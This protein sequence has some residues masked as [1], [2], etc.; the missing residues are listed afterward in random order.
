[1]AKS[2]TKR[3]LVGFRDV[4][5]NAHAFDDLTNQIRNKSKQFK[6]R[7]L[8]PNTWNKKGVK[9]MKFDAV[10]GNPPYQDSEKVNN[11]QGAI[12]HY[13]YDI[14]SELS[15][16]YSLI[17]PARFLFNTGFTP[18][19]WN[20]KMLNDEH[21]NIV[22]Y[23]EDATDIFPRT[24][25]KGGIIISYHDMKQNFGAIKKFVPDK[26]LKNIMNHFSCDNESNLPSIMYGGRSDLKFNN[27]FIK[28][29]P[30]SIQDRI[31]VIKLKHP[32][33]N[34]LSPNEEFELKSSTFEV[35]PYAFSETNIEDADTYKILGLI[36]GK[37]VYR[38]IPRKYMVA[39]YPERNNINAYKVFVPESNGSGTFG[40]I[41]STPVV[42]EPYESCT[43][44]F[45]SIGN[46]ET[47]IE[48]ENT[49]KYIKTKLCR[50][51]LGIMKKTQ[52]NSAPNWAYIPIQD[53]TNNSDIDWSKNIS[54]ID[55]QLYSK[56][57]LSE[58][59]ITYIESTIR[60]ME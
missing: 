22:R 12:Y 53:F 55:K 28:D 43:P 47:K 50:A 37:R 34:S 49:L 6:E 45:I 29:Y 57:D 9:E 48:A 56:Y 44:T 41:L 10:V 5:I 19:E 7:I 15:D 23:E 35:L 51:L 11:R 21:F 59:E 33:V 40:E 4:K 46:F 13:F 1:M 17:S 54:E 32:N 27:T 16:R 14:A 20:K 26:H 39:R 3:T 8:N 38:Y 18:K 24:D 31:N 2:I 36:A 25:I 58:E 42:A 60:P 52:H 30:N